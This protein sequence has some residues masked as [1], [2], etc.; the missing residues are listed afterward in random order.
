[1]VVITWMTIYH[2]CPRAGSGTGAGAIP[3]DQVRGGV[4]G[5]DCFG[6]M[7][8]TLPQLKHENVSSCARCSPD[9]LP[10]IAIPQMGQC[11]ILGRS[12]R[13]LLICA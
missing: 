4:P 3:A 11:L 13:E 7:V 5:L 1:L 8:M 2:V 12:G 9:L 6:A 10:I